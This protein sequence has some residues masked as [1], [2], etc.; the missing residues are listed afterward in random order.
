MLSFRDNNDGGGWMATGDPVSSASAR[1][2]LS[3][4]L[5]KIGCPNP[6]IAAILVFNFA[7]GIVCFGFF[8]ETA[9]MDDTQ[10][11]GKS[12]FTSDMEEETCKWKNETIVNMHIGSYNQGNR[13]RIQ[14]ANGV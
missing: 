8:A 14:R 4:S 2:P 13:F 3:S 6:I 7:G 9:V 5:R 10:S 1:T 12:D 11:W